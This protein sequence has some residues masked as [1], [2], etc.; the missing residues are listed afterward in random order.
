MPELLTY[1]KHAVPRE[2]AAQIR[3]YVRIQW[4]HLNDRYGKLWNIAPGDATTFVIVEDE[5]V[6]SHAEA[7][8]K[9]FPFDG[10]QLTILGLSAVFTYPAWRNA[11][12]A[13]Q[14]VGA[15]TMYMLNDPHADA[16]ILFCA[17]EKVPFYQSLGWLDIPTTT[18]LEG[19]PANP[20]IH[21][22]RMMFLPINDAGRALHARF[23]NTT[24]YVG[25]T[26][27]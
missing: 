25:A 2:I 10:R 23:H 13:K 4:P 22:C 7:K 18:T 5:V 12:Y 21:E 11:G 24:V 1:P 3:S 14:V 19:D 8:R 16:G 9:D 6:V 17:V 26:T 27:W 20:R 15:A